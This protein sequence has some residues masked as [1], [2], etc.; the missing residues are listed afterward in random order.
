MSLDADQRKYLRKFVVEDVLKTEKSIAHAKPFEDQSEG[1][2]RAFVGRLRLRW[3]FQKEVLAALDD[4][5]DPPSEG[6]T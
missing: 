5:D 4:E 3:S 1:E 2:F 6:E